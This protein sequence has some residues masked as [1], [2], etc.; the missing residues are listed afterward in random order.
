[1]RVV[2]PRPL[3]LVKVDTIVIKSFLNSVKSSILLEEKV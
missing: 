3:R 2:S 1:V